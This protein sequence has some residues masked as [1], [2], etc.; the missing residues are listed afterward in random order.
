MWDLIHGYSVCI[1]G[2]SMFGKCAFEFAMYLDFFLRKK[3]AVTC[4]FWHVCFTTTSVCVKGR[5]IDGRYHC[6]CLFLVAFLLVQFSVQQLQ[7]VFS[8]MLRKGSSRRH[9]K[10]S[11]GL[12]CDCIGSGVIN[13]KNTLYESLFIELAQG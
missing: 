5:L 1:F 6:Y 4:A 8:N 13:N 12:Y 9:A 11:K 2:T 7:V 10:S 3:M